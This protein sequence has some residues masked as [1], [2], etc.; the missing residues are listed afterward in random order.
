M[1]P[2]AGLFGSCYIDHDLGPDVPSHHTEFGFV[3]RGTGEQIFTLPNT[4]YI[5]H[6][7]IILTFPGV[8]GIEVHPRLHRVTAEANEN[9]EEKSQDQGKF[10]RGSE[11]PLESVCTD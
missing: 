1:S 6:S 8:A 4:N 5:L 2:I 9:T 3:Y 10:T 7:N 11:T